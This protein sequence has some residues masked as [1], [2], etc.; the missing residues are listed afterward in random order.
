[1]VFYRSFPERIVAEFSRDLDF[2]KAREKPRR[3]ANQLLHLIRYNFLTC[4]TYIEVVIQVKVLQGRDNG[5]RGITGLSKKA[6]F[7]K[8]RF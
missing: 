6:I 7:P 2:R 3:K 5:A 1:M 4:L 8:Y